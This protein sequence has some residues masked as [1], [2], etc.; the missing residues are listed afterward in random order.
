MTCCAAPLLQA[1]APAIALNTPQCCNMSISHMLVGRAQNA[2]SCWVMMMRCAR[3]VQEA[4]ARLCM[5][6]M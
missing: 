4:L 6:H 2:V 3:H 1:P 5:L